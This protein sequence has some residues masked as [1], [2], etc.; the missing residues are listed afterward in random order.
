MREKI[1]GKPKVCKKKYQ[2]RRK[3]LEKRLEKA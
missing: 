3:S 1:R 2:K